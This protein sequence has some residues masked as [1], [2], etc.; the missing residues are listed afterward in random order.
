MKIPPSVRFWRR[1]VRTPEGCLLWTG[2]KDKDGYGK[3]DNHRAHVFAYIDRVGPVPPGLQLNH[4]CPN[5]AC[6]IHVYPG[7]Q[8][9]NIADAMAAGTRRS[10]AREQSHVAKLKEVDVASIRERY[11]AGGIFQW[12]LAQEYG[13]VRQTITRIVNLQ[14]WK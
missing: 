2:A 7:T 10:T 5:K 11:A 3:F 14:N 4:S 8:K 6:V 12:Q 13:V 1:V 9:Q